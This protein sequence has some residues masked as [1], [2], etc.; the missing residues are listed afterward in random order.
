MGGPAV[1]LAAAPPHFGLG[2]LAGILAAVCY[3]FGSVLQAI[4]AQR[5]AMAVG[6]DPRLVFRLLRQ[7]PY[8]FGLALDGVGFVANVIALQ[9][10]PLFLVQSMIAGSVGVTAVAALRLLHV[11]LS[12]SS[13]YALIVLVLGLS[14]LAIG[15]QPGAARPQTRAFEWGLLLVS[16]GIAG[17]A[18]AASH[19]RGRVGV[20]SLAAIA[21]TAFGG[22]GVSARGLE[23][24]HPIWSVVARPE[25][26]ALIVFGILG[27]LVFATALQRGSVTVASGI[28]FAAETVLPSAI[29]LTLLGDATRPEFGAGVAGIGFVLTL[30]GAIALARYSE[31]LPAPVPSN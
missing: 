8:V 13:V 10:L 31:P 18:V 19:V 6:L 25:F 22:V 21:G 12:R 30:G 9:W 5:T 16:I 17:L 20:F 7:L 23:V 4:G 11:S 27:T 14:L 29:G 24:P 15:A 2:L 28:M 26:W 3:G 1:L